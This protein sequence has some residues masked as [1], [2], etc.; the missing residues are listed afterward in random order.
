MSPPASQPP[1]T[2]RSVYVSYRHQGESQAV[3][4]G[5]RAA[6]Q[7]RGIEL[8]TDTGTIR[9]KDPIRRYMQDLGA[10]RC[11]IVVL[12]DGYLESPN[13]MF[14]LLEV[15]KN[16]EFHQRV[17]PI[18]LRGT[19]IYDPEDRLDFIQHWQDKTDALNTKVRG[20]KS[21][22]N[23]DRV[24]RDLSLYA[25]IRRAIDGLMDTLA[26]MYTPNEDAHRD[27]DFE[28]LLDAVEAHL[29]PT[30]DEQARFE[31]FRTRVRESIQAE[32]ERPGLGP[33]RA[34]L[35][36][37]LSALPGADA[38]ALATNLCRKDTKT[39]VRGLRAAVDEALKAPAQSAEARAALN[40]PARALLGWLVLLSVREDWLQGR[41]GPGPDPDQVMEVR[42]P[43]ETE[44]GTE[45]LVARLDESPARFA[46]DPKGM[47]VY[48]GRHAMAG[49]SIPE[50]G[51]SDADQANEIKRAIWKAVFKATPSA[52]WSAEMDQ[53]LDETLD[54]RR[55]TG[56]GHYI[57][58]RLSNPGE[59]LTLP[60]VCAALHR[61][62][63]HL[64]LVFLQAPGGE[65]V[66]LIPERT[67]QVLIRE[68]LRTLEEGGHA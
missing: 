35:A 41:L 64:Q 52:P 56:E 10:G 51:L 7:A 2:T 27:T 32:L 14:E 55:D 45:V 44:A 67:L 47:R 37:K 9:Y 68:F 38:G 30:P 29:P 43:V 48:G 24:Q 1:P 19:R 34:A 15:E 63:P 3:V 62:L 31:R 58:V 18:V 53:E 26:D 4:E 8:I 60:A 22:A 13:C 46:T 42:L 50:V 6:C 61:D 39:A 59:P 40:E 54:V 20:L 17:F 33:L 65:E 23:L 21:L 5:L 36:A 25:D 57:T 11:V 66:L 28:A 49:S 16:R 12:S